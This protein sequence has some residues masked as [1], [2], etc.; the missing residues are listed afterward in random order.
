MIVIIIIMMTIIVII[1][2]FHVAAGVAAG[3]GAGVRLPID[4]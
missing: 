2:R 1:I 3:E 4:L